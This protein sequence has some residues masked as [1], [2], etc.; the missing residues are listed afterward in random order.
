MQHKKEQFHKLENS[1]VVDIPEETERNASTVNWTSEESL[2]RE[3]QK[4][5]VVRIILSTL[6]VWEQVWQ[7]RGLLL[8]SVWE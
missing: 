3:K 4:L 5:N 8:V 1:S 7:L 2:Q 6:Q